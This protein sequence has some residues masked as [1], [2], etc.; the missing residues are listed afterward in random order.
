MEDTFYGKA[1][2]NFP[3]DMQLSFLFLELSNDLINLVPKD[4]LRIQLN[5]QKKCFSTLMG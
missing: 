4:I 3:S 2:K 5:I 1:Y